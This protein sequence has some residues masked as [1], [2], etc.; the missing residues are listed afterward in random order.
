MIIIDG[1]NVYP[2]EVEEVLYRHPDVKDCAMIGVLIDD[3]KEMGVM[4]VAPKDGR[5]PGAKELRDY[6][7]AHVAHYKV[8][9]RF[10]VLDELPRNPTGK[11]MKKELRKQYAEKEQAHRD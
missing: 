8:P 4:Y 3:A 2:Y 6:L 11:I 5:K 9:R 1:L 7:S 10:L